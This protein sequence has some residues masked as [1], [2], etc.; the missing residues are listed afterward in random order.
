MSIPDKGTYHY[1]CAKETGVLLC[2]KTDPDA[3]QKVVDEI[4]DDADLME[5]GRTAGG[6]TNTLHESLRRLSENK[7]YLNTLL[8]VRGRRMQEDYE[9]KRKGV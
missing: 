7:E 6:D 9:K 1:E 2:L 8:M 4:K 5:M 3:I